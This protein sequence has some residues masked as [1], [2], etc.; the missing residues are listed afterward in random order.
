MSWYDKQMD[1][2]AANYYL[3]ECRKLTGKV[4]RLLRD[5]KNCT[6][7]L[8]YEQNA[9]DKDMHEMREALTQAYEGMDSF[10]KCYNDVEMKHLKSS[11]QNKD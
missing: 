9:S 3:W 7:G 1:R 10:S 5:L 2:D 6:S 11:K 8:R 4:F